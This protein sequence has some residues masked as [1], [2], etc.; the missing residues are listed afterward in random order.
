MPGLLD[1]RTKLRCISAWIALRVAL[2]P[3]GALVGEPEDDEE[4]AKDGKDDGEDKEGHGC[5][6]HR[7][8]LLAPLGPP[9]EPRAL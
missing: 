8:T 3:V 9:A 2:L 6:I 1:D 4:R 5:G 7:W